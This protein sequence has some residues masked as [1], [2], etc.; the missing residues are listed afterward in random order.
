[1]KYTS[2]LQ[3]PLNQTSYQQTTFGSQQPQVPILPP[4]SQIPK[5]A[6]PGSRTQHITARDTTFLTQAPHPPEPLLPSAP[7]LSPVV[8]Q[9]FELPV[10]SEPVYTTIADTLPT[11]LQSGAFD[12]TGSTKYTYETTPSL[13][14]L[15]IEPTSYQMGSRAIG[16]ISRAKS[17]PGRWESYNNQ[18][19]F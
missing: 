1:M 13:N 7:I 15:Q 16:P 8:T 6:P 12:F 4:A 14:K 5:S 3:T 10:S 2:R 19:H 11:T 18:T 9:E 17:A